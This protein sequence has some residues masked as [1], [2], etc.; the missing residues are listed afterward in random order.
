MVEDDLQPMAL[1]VMDF[2][3]PA[4][5]TLR[6]QFVDA[7]LIDYDS[8]AAC[9]RIGYGPIYAREY[10][11]RFLQEPYV[12]QRIAEKERS[13]IPTLAPDD[14]NTADMKQFV[15]TS[16]IKEASYKGPGCS[17]AARVAALAKLA[18]L[19]G[20]DMAIKSEI[21]TTGSGMFVIPGLMTPEE[22]EAQA[23]Q[24]QD[25]LVN[26]VPAEATAATVAIA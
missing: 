25:A 24:Q 4:E 13:K 2:L 15:I 7:Y 11:T 16:L 21:T 17:Q 22:W 9:V 1:P 14:A 18:S 3:S 20:M 23:G 10:S 12:A 19:H 6:N 5:K 26:P 8:L